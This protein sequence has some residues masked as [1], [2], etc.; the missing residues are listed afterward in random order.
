MTV[1][2]QNPLLFGFY[3]L[4]PETCSPLS[5]GPCC[6]SAVAESDFDPLETCVRLERLEAELDH[7][8]ERWVLGKGLPVRAVEEPH[9]KTRADRSLSYPLVFRES[10]GRPRQGG[11]PSA[12]W[13]RTAA[14]GLRVPC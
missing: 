1:L 10:P 8:Q 12:E 2:R 9:G 3:C 11:A 4:S 5:I 7:G 14:C 13:A 6:E